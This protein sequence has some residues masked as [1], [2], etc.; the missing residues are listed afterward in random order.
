VKG[1]PCPIFVINL[2]RSASR[3]GHVERQIHSAGL[4]FERIPGIDGRELPDAEIARLCPDNSSC[5]YAPLRPGEVGCYLSHL[6]A[7]QVAEARGLDRFVVFEDDFELEPG[8]AD[9]LRDLCVQG[10]KLPDAVKL[11]GRRGR[12]E[13]VATLPSGRHVVRSSSPPICTV[14]TLWTIAGARKLVSA[15]Q[16]LRRP[17]DVE[18]KHWWET[19]LDVVWVAPPPV[20]D[21]SVLMSASTIGSRKVRG[22]GARLRQLDYRLRYAARREAHFARRHGVT[23]WL[24][25]LLPVPTPAHRTP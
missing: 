16:T 21:S 8:F 23:A 17:I 24:R 6:R 4:E 25:S 18:L 3:L 2:D 19:N 1:S 7:L 14:A 10:V 9:C 12:G 11:H 20:R 13:V 22:A 15:S 5:F